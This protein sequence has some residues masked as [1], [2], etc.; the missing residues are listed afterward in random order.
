[1]SSL[2]FHICCYITSPDKNS[3][4]GQPA[5]DERKSTHDEFAIWLRFRN[6]DSVHEGE[7]GVAGQANGCGYLQKGVDLVE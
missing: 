5:L 6:S 7:D 4:W 3:L 1:M 2:C